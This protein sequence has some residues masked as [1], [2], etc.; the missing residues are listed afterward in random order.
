[1]FSESESISPEPNETE[2][3]LAP[4]SDVFEMSDEDF[5]NYYGSS[6]EVKESSSQSQAKKAYEQTDDFED[7]STFAYSNSEEEDLPENSVFETTEQTPQDEQ[8]EETDQEINDQKDYTSEDINKILGTPIKGAGKEIILNN[9]E[10]AIRLI[11]MGMGYHK[12]MEQ[13]KPHR[14]VISL[15]EKNNLLDQDKLNYMVDLM[16][17]EPKA[18]Q[19]LV[20]DSEIDLYDFGLDDDTSE[21]QPTDHSI[22]DEDMALESAIKDIEGTPTYSKTINILGSEWDNAS[23][24]FIRQNPELIKLINEHVQT[25]VFDTVSNEVEKY[26]MLG[27]LPAGLSDIQA[28]KYVGDAL[29]T[30]KSQ[31]HA[32]RNSYPSQ[33]GY[34]NKV[35]GNPPIKTPSRETVNQRKRATSVTRGQS[36]ARYT[37]SRDEVWTMDDD[38]FLKLFGTGR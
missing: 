26:K 16:N 38:D 30:D 37:P 25:G 22:S 20:K 2:A 29:Y 33:L 9:A 7:S 34:G 36:K 31:N 15:L 3:S 5:L 18:I 28:Y 17:K 35:N 12:T 10:D 4:T 21:Y 24:N 14:K 8:I 1:M 23:R 32:Q 11:Q 13:M 27:K 6:T 19:K